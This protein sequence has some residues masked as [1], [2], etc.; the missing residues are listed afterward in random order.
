LSTREN[1][2]QVIT[3]FTVV[4]ARRCVKLL[5]FQLSIALTSAVDA[6]QRRPSHTSSRSRSP[7]R[8][9]LLIVL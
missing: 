1:S 5:P 9:R 4:K 3:M 6:L 8:R 7:R 2:K